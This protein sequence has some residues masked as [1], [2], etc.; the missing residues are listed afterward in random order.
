MSRRKETRRV[1]VGT[2]RIDDR[3]I[4]REVV[5][6]L[7][8]G[9]LDVEIVPEFLPGNGDRPP[10]PGGSTIKIYRKADKDA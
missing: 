2:I 6:G 10:M 4:E 5:R 3:R 8:T 1:L 7:R 9:G